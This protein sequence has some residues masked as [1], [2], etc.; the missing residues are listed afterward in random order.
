MGR[1]VDI[2][3]QSPKSN[4]SDQAHIALS[5]S[6]NVMPALTRSAVRDGEGSSVARALFAV[7]IA[8][9]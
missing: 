3:K 2:R 7:T 1:A 5:M 6:K 4:A 8:L 9:V